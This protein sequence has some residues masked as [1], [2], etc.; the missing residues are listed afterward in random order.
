MATARTVVLPGSERTPLAWAYPVGKPDPEER[1]EVLV[2]LRSRAGTVAP[3]AIAPGGPHLSREEFAA[4]YAA[5]SDDV[6]KVEAFAQA[7][8]LTVADISL[9]ERT[10]A[11]SGTVAAMSAAFG[12]DLDV[13]E[14]PEGRYRGRT[15]SI[16]IPSTL[17]DIVQGVFGLDDRPVARPHYRLQAEPQGLAPNATPAGYTPVDLAKLYSFPAKLDGTGECIA[18]LELGGGYRQADLVAYFKG[19][20]LPVPAVSAVSVGATN[21]PTTPSSPDVEVLLDIEVAGAVAPGA[22]IVVYFAPNT[23]AGFLKAITT[24]AHDSHHKPSVISISW[25]GPESGWPPQAL[26]AFDRAF[27]DA[28]A[29][30]VTVL[31]AAGDDGSSDRV[32]DGAAHVDFPASSPHV[33]ACGGTRLDSAAGKITG[34]TVWNDGPGQGATGGGV[35]GYFPLPAWQ[36][37]AHVPPSVNDGRAGRGVP[38]VSGDA[39]PNTGYRI[40]VDGKAGVVGGTSAVA[41]LWA[42]LVALC[43]QKL[44]KQ[45]GFLNPVLYGPLA[46][47]PGLRDVTVGNNGAYHAGPGWDSCTGLGSPNGAALLKALGTAH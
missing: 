39:D 41:P 11:L 24:A 43:N 46:G 45:V 22:S 2:V 47:G 40:L 17:K 38:D 16:R 36:A 26:D 28:A 44:A 13:Y 3:A 27:A 34:E 32:N 33:V 20:G 4:G 14:S 29:M 30:G 10:V 8:D 35:S 21:S 23:T 37:N 6:A 7:H 42:G 12:V 25:G 15:G 5:A 1:I 19:L 31:C 18:I 9:Q